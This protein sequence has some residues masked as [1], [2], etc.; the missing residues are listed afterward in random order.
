M[1]RLSPLRA[2]GLALLAAWVLP[3]GAAGMTTHAL[4]ADFGR[5]ALAEGPL[6][7]IL[8]A[9]RASL[10]AGAI[11]P[12][13]GYGSGAAFPEDREVAERAHWEDFT[14][15]FIEHLQSLG[16]DRELRSAL[17]QPPWL[18]G[19]GLLDLNQ[20][21]DRCG[22]LIAFSFGNAAHGLTD[23]TWDS[24]F[25]PLV[26]ERAEDPNPAAFLAPLLA[27]VPDGVSGPLYGLFGA[28]PLNAIEYAMDMVAIV[29]HNLW[30]DAPT[31]QFPPVEDLVAVY[32]RNRPEQGV[33][34]AQVL[35]GIAVSR[36]AVQAEALGAAADHLRIRLQMPWASAHYY[37]AAGGVADSGYMVA[38][39]YRHLW[40]KLLG[41]P[42]PI[43]IVGTHPRHGAVD[44]PV[45]RD[46]AGLSIRAFTG[47]SPTEV[48]VEL[49]GTLCLYD[50]Q[51]RR[52][53]GEVRSGIYDPEYGHVL[54]FTPAA[55]L[56]PDTRYTVVVTRQLRDHLDQVP[57]NAHS[58]SF[59]TAAQSR[60]PQTRPAR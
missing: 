34:A 60:E 29:D 54:A 42:L 2:G 32:A 14:D 9:H 53:E 12:D 6:R 1:S 17:P 46:A 28:T 8:D 10:L 26:R 19:S 33:T 59:V 20:I 48:S 31:L 7:Q 37:T 47:Q 11:H 30:L 22:S 25:E 56:D 43:A 41:E 40:A 55:D 16:C 39:L 18:P 58:W 24:L 23:E 45:G 38:G 57:R 15:R 21:T 5:E 4:M 52:I 44:V 50:E 3:A 49:P 36:A 27:S 51:G 13:G 35:R